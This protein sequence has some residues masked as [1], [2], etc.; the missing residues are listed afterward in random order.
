MNF[1]L[2]LLSLSSSKPLYNT[3]YLMSLYYRD[4]LVFLAESNKPL[5]RLDIW[6]EVFKSLK[7]R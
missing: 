4:D 2:S 1:W 5:T 6:R 7:L 3:F